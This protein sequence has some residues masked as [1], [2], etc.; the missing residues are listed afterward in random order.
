MS[1]PLQ[2]LRDIHPGPPPSA[3]WLS[4]LGPFVLLGLLLLLIGFLLYRLWP[5]ARAY[6][7]LRLLSVE[8]D[9]FMPELNLW[10]KRT[11]LLC[12]SRQDIAPLHGMAW[13]T[14]LDR[15]GHSQFVKFS[16]TWD[17]WSYGLHTLNEQDRRA[18][19]QES[20]RWLR[21]QIRR[22]LCSR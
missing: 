7:Q 8:P 6:R 4:S 1:Y 2:Q 21:A 17:G 9:L 13:L 10:L 12:E 20:R 14:F 11:A 15:S 18:V 5:L 16:T 3:G 22:R 19:L